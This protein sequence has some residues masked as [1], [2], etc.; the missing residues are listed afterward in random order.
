MND[1]TLQRINPAMKKVTITPVTCYANGKQMT[2][3]QF[4]VVSVSDNLF[5][6]VVFKYTLFTEKGEWAGEAAFTLDGCDCY[7]KWDA[8]PE[9]A[10][11]IVAKGV[12]LEMIQSKSGAIFPE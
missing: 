2:A 10:Y 5:D 7:D 6:K 12:G 1:Q 4:N 8:S 11:T 9:G 3:T